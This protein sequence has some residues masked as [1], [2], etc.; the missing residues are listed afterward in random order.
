MGTAASN[1][2]KPSQQMNVLISEIADLDEI[3]NM[4]YS[5]SKQNNFRLLY[6]WF[7]TL[8]MFLHFYMLSS[9]IDPLV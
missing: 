5:Q 1:L 9:P 7:T 4:V 3:L 8:T 2:R 6:M